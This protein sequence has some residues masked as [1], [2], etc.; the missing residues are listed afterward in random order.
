LTDGG[1]GIPGRDRF[2]RVMMRALLFVAGRR[3]I[4]QIAVT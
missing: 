4:T 3:I 2:G 1:P